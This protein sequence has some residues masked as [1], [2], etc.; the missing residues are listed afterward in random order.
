MIGRRRILSLFGG[1]V[2]AAASGV[3]VKD[4]MAL[5]SSMT[6]IPEGESLTSTTAVGVLDAPEKPR[7]W[8]IINAMRQRH[9]ETREALHEKMGAHI[10]TKKSWSPAFKEHVDAQE[11]REFREFMHR[12]ERDQKFA[13]RVAGILGWKP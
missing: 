7:H 2:G 6:P 10:A 11:I 9:Y 1:A 3:S 8:R 4:A 12:L 5:S 13:D